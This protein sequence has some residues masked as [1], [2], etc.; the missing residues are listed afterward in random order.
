M[1]S[2]LALSVN[3]AANIYKGKTTRNWVIESLLGFPKVE[4]PEWTFG[5]PYYD[6]PP[7]GKTNA[8]YSLA[9]GTNNESD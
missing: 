4:K 9:K 8:F 2:T 5:Q 6:V 7:S 3:I 1:V